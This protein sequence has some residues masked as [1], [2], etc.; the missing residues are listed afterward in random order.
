LGLIFEKINGYKDGSY[1]TPGFITTY[2]CREVIRNAV[3]SK[4][5]EVKGWKTKTLDDV[6]NKI[7]DIP[8]ANDIVN[9]I[10]ICDPTVGSGHFLV[11]ALNEIIAVK[12]DLGIL[13]DDRGRKLRG[14]KIEVVND[15]LMIFDENGDFYAYNFRNEESRKIQQTI[16]QEKRLIIENCLFGVDINPNS[17]KICRLRL[18]IELLKNAYYT[19]QSK[20]TELETLPNIDIN[21][22]CGNSLIS[23]FDVDID[24][25]EELKKL[26]YSV[27][28]Y[29]EAVHQYKNAESKDEKAKLDKLILEIK[30]NFRGEAEKHSKLNQKIHRLHAELASFSQQEF[31]EVSKTEQVKKEK[32]IN[33]ISNEIAQ[34]EQQIEDIKTNKIYDNAFEWRFEF[35]EVLNDNGDFIGFDAVIGNPPYGVEIDKKFFRNQ[36][37]MCD[38]IYTLFLEKGQII[39]KSLS[40]IS[41]IIPIFWLTGD[42][43]INTRKFILEKLKLSKG[44]ILPYDVFADAYID[45]GI[46]IFSKNSETNKSSVYSFNPRDKV[47]FQT[48]LNV[49]FDEISEIEWR[50]TNDLKL[51]FDPI[52]RSLTKKFEQF[53]TTI[54]NVC[55]SARGILADKS[56][57]LSQK[58]V[59]TVP[60]FIGKLN[61]YAMDKECSHIIYDDS[62]KE[63]P[64]SYTFFKGEKI[65][66]RRIVSRQFRL[67]ATLHKGELV[68]KKDIY[69]FKVDNSE[70]SAKYILSIINSKLIS[71]MLTKGSAA[72]RKDD[73]T[74]ITLNDIRN[75]HIQKPTDKQKVE[76]ENLV[77][78]ILKNTR[79]NSESE[80]KI[81]GLIYQ[82][83]SL[84]CEEI[85]IIEKYHEEY[86]KN[87]VTSTRKEVQ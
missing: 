59:N 74:Q 72:A 6:F 75:I 16:F 53:P 7:E 77:T 9:S 21:I 37:I 63:K 18:W 45:T 65:L 31:F 43:Y 81:D 86:S 48:L 3:V 85:Q 28:D 60:V 46:F 4:F 57:Y 71:Y 79:C 19:E 47:D 20:Y 58:S 50:K 15:E 44:I 56:S 39:G 52:S 73:F 67:M 61:R 51:I 26:K 33:D 55:L 38:D 87:R 36:Y 54:G 70:Y 22:K 1:F 42:A 78:D 12:S 35:P 13:A 5:N 14:Y 10:T 64:Q 8:E 80:A 17:V 68:V 49:S 34:I 23:R 27:K 40:V 41:F 2:I 82:L 83:Y 76:I 11:S 69:I 25:K 29:Q 32:R 62:L 66:I 84:S 30:N 24:L